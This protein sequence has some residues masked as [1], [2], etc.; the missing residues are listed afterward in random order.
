MCDG[1]TDILAF[2]IGLGKTRCYATVRW[3]YLHRRYDT[4][5]SYTDSFFHSHRYASTRYDEPLL[6]TITTP[7]P[8]TIQHF[9][10]PIQFFIDTPLPVT[11]N[12]YSLR[13]NN[14]TNRYDTTLSYTD[15][16]FIHTP[17]P[18]TM[19]HYSLRYDT[20]TPLPVT[21]KHFPMPRHF[22]IDTPL[23][24]T[25]NHYSIRCSTTIYDVPH[26]PPVRIHQHHYAL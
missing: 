3:L 7:I 8:V 6:V 10:M 20:T 11:I 23:P 2:I 16:F 9:L 26:Y 17:L 14:T 22:F 15:T 19:N 13:Y 21:I 5:L 4:A 24:V 25:M 12:H 18:V 1:R